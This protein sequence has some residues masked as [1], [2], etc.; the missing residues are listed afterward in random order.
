[1]VFI[2]DNAALKSDV[3]GAAALTNGIRIRV[4]N[5]SDV[6]LLDV[7]AGVP[8]KRLADL[9]A[10][11]AEQLVDST[12]AAAGTNKYAAYV[13][14]FENP[15]VLNGSTPSRLAVTLNDD[16]SNLVILKFLALGIK[17]GQIVA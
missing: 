2:E 4:L 3:F 9:M 7:D 1:M 10:L 11:G 17:R 12:I 5:G 13:L 15:V 6:S 8:I 16:L 14:K